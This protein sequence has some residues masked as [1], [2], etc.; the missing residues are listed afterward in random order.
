MTR[1]NFKD[2]GVPA[3]YI[4]W[5][6]DEQTG[7]IPI[8][9]DVIMIGTELYRVVDRLIA[10]SGVENFENGIHALKVRE[11]TLYLEIIVCGPGEAEYRDWRDL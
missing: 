1:L 9:G 5:S 3:P 10:Y 11:I 6:A 8:A 4:V 2:I 7:P